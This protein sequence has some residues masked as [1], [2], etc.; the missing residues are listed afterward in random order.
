MNPPEAKLTIINS[1]GKKLVTVLKDA[2]WGEGVYQLV[3]VADFVFDESE[4]VKYKDIERGNELH[5]K[6]IDK[7]K[8]K[9][10]FY[11]WI[12]S[13]TINF[14]HGKT[15]NESKNEVVIKATSYPSILTKHT[16][17]GKHKFSQGYGQIVKQFAR[18]YGFQTNDVKLLKKSGEIFF[19]KMPILEA[20]RRMASLEGWCFKFRDKNL[21]FGPCT[22]PKESGVVI[23]E[24]EMISG[25]FTK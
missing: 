2:K 1:E 18:K 10:T 3:D 16:I 24:K 5:L 20:M 21:I 4:K 23:T 7:N 17:E 14:E 6:V 15:E 19:R 11:Y 13:V 22:P 8:V 12:E 9:K 25:S